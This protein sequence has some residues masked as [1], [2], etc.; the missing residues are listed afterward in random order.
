MDTASRPYF[1][2]SAR[3]G[4][5]EWTPADLPLA[6]SLWGDPQITRFVGGPFSREQVSRRLDKEISTLQSHR[7]QYWPIFLLGNGNFVGAAG[8]RPYKLE[9]RIFALGF[10]L[11]REYWR[12]GLAEEAA[13][14]VIDY[15][16]GTLNATRLF[17]GHHPENSA[18]R[19]LLTKLGFVFSHEELYPPTGIN[20]PGYFL[21]R[22]QAIC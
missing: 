7:A 22:P 1:L 20:H 15:A 5:G 2:R 9:D 12:Q 10:Y 18:S 11:L 3:L 4:F 21:Q 13:R 17:A 6:F 8:L 19:A 14:A 16:F